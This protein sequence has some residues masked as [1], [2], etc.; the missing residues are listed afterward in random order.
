MQESKRIINY[1]ENM[2]YFTHTHTH[3]NED[4]LLNGA[5]EW[6]EWCDYRWT[7]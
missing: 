7:K 2:A 5:A 3:T 6:A 4:A 1:S